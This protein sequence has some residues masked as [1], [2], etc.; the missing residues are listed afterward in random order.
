METWRESSDHNYLWC[1]QPDTNKSSKYVYNLISFYKTLKMIYDC[2]KLSTQLK[3]V[4][5]V[6][7]NILLEYRYSLKHNVE[8]CLRRDHVIELLGNQMNS[9]YSLSW[10]SLYQKK[11]GI[12][13]NKFYPRSDL[14]KWQWHLAKNQ[15]REIGNNANI[16][17]RG[18]TTWKTSSDK[19][20]PP[21][22]I[23]PR[24]L[25]TSD[26]KPDTILS[27][28]TWHVLLMRSLNFC[29]CTTW[30]LDLDDLKQIN[31]AWLYKEPKVSVLQGNVKLV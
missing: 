23:E 6:N 12:V 27:T 18:F 13:Q 29:S 22:G 26:S 21:V 9:N 30:Y 7:V 10:Q 4:R 14:L 11:K 31:R 1:G 19:M 20:L 25:I 16:G 8:K 24:P 28:L 17:I 5:I 2:V 15:A 3:T